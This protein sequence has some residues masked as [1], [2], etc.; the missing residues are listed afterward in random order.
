MVRPWKAP[1]STREFTVTLTCKPGKGPLLT[2]SL[3]PL[4]WG[5]REAFIRIM[6]PTPQDYY[7]FL[8]GSSQLTAFRSAKYT[9]ES[10]AE[11]KSAAGEPKWEKLPKSTKYEGFSEGLVW[12]CV[13][14]RQS[15]LFDKN[16]LVARIIPCGL[17][18]TNFPR[19]GKNTTLRFFSNLFYPHRFYHTYLLLWLGKKR[20]TIVKFW[21]VIT[22]QHLKKV[23]PYIKKKIPN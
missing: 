6:R 18:L 14:R 5:K 22:I 2:V 23:C 11:P 7:Y 12:L 9:R 4:W 19:P 20:D 21:K 3:L 13:D 1:S 8:K 10:G 17:I 15:L 16:D